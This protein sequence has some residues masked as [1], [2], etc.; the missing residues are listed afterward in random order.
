MRDEL[1][2]RLALQQAEKAYELGEIP[3]GALV[4]CQDEVIA[5]AHNEKEAL[6][7]ATAHAEILAL[8]RAARY[9]GQWRL[10]GATLYCTMEPCPMCAGAMVNSRLSRLV[11][12]CIDD[13]AGSAGSILDIVRHPA[14]NHQVE[15]KPGV[16]EEECAEVLSRFFT[17][18]RRDGRDGRR[19]STRNRVGG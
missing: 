10:N 3:I 4:V 6:K 18:L 11:Y 2:M 19:R 13:K 7:D 12:G 17:D 9:L 16:L 15:V 8:Q 5:W 1:Y 14:L